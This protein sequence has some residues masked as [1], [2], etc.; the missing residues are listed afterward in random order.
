MAYWSH[1]MKTSSSTS[2]LDGL[3]QND[4]TCFLC[5][6]LTND[7]GEPLV[8]GKMLRRCGCAFHVHPACW[9]SWLASGRGDFDCPI[10]RKSSLRI[11]IPDEM[12]PPLTRVRAQS[13]PYADESFICCCDMPDTYT[14]YA[15]FSAVVLISGIVATVMLLKK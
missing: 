11:I 4:P 10:C 15:I 7:I 2:S 13:F 8:D 1:K 14:S 6:E 3:T 9:N 5:L 12:A